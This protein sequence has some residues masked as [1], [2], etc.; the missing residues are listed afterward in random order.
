M[1]PIKTLAEYAANT[2]FED[3]PPEVIEQAKY[4]ILDTIGCALGGSKTELGRVVTETIGNLGG[5]PEATIVGEKIKTNCVLAAYVNAI[6]VDALDFED[7][8]HGLGHPSATIIP[9]ALSVGEKT[10]AGGKE[11]ITAIVSA[12]EVAVRMGLTMRPSTRKGKLGSFQYWHVF[13]AAASA[14]RILKL[15]TDEIMM[16]F[17]YAG[18]SAPLP[19]YCVG[20]HSTWIK[21]NFGE[22][23]A[24]GILG[25][26]LAEKG[27]IAPKSPDLDYWYRYQS[28]RKRN[29]KMTHKLG[30]EY[31]ILLA[32]FK[33]YT[34]C[35]F[36]HSALGA[37]E[38]LLKKNHIK[39]DQI[40]KVVL[41][42]HRDVAE[43]FAVYEPHNMV[44]AEFSFP[45]V[46][47]MVML[48]KKPG[49]DW[50]SKET[51]NDPE[52]LRNAKKVEIK[53]SE[54]SNKL[55]NEEDYRKRRVLAELELYLVQGKHYRIR[56]RLSKGDP[57]D[58]LTRPQLAQKFTD[59]AV[60]AKMCKNRARKVVE[61]A[62]NL[63]NLENIQR[64]GDLLRI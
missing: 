18:A 38:D 36:L 59:L 52:T 5:N 54:E 32:G 23:T 31:M 60:S 8:F 55:L 4:L 26:L 51:M 39:A 30:K 11:V 46:A 43:G 64:L 9:A 37:L 44:D 40:R 27:Y 29:E 62:A 33:P 49:L 3:L 61:M 56:T 12:Y 22:I 21:D 28:Q 42:S 57:S 14:S 41:H 10:G 25:A 50:Y 48:G 2:Q 63:E 19:M 7:T 20:R 58:P 6:L 45:Y 1:D 13:G 15:G 47:A 16:S 24:A 53:Y 34:A 17:G 35:R